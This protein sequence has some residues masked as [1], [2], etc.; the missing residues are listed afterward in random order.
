MNYGYIRPIVNDQHCTKQLYERSIDT[1]FKETHGLARKRTELEH[2]LMTV[3]K[4][5]T[6][7]VQKYHSFSRFP[8]AP[9]R[10]I[11]TS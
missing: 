6:L 1:L 7:F 4:D 8:P 2:L 3:Q 5:D 10:Y 11:T 9:F